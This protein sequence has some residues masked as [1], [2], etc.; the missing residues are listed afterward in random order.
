M[1]QGSG[2][3]LGEQAGEFA[4]TLNINELPQHN[5]LLQGIAATQNSTVPASRYLANT[6]GALTVYGPAANFTAMFQG[7]ISLTGGSQPH[8]NQSPYLVLTWIIA[9]QGI[10]PTQT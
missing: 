6:Q 3:T 10:F 4:H 7:D 8:N 5:H 2:H 9:L 1:H